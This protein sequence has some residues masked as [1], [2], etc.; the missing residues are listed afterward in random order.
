MK[1]YQDVAYL[2]YCFI[3]DASG[4]WSNG[5]DFENDLAQFFESKGLEA[6]ILNAVKGTPGNRRIVVITKQPTVPTTPPP[7][8]KGQPTQ[9]L[10]QI[11]GENRNVKPQG[12]VRTG[13][14]NAFKGSKPDLKVSPGK[15]FNTTFK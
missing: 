2:E 7:M 8:P 10:K 1:D 5:Y 3:F 12:R 4:V 13:P 15:K 14:L 6:K 9:I 11:S